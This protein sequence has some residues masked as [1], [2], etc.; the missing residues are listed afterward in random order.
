MGWC[1]SNN[2]VDYKLPGEC[3]VSGGETDTVRERENATW[4]G[5]FN[6]RGLEIVSLHRP[7]AHHGG[8]TDDSGRGSSHQ[9]LRPAAGAIPGSPAPRPAPRGTSGSP[10]GACADQ[11]AHRCHSRRSRS[12]RSCR[13]RSC[14]SCR[15]RSCCSCQRHRCR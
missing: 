2:T 3:T 11:A 14:R 9:A 1:R 7:S 8:E 6:L 13:S 12:C 4:R 15:S 10:G 5:R